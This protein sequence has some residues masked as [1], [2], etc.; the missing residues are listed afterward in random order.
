MCGLGCGAALLIHNMCCCHRMVQGRVEGCSSA[1]NQRQG[2]G[3]AQTHRHGYFSV[4]GLDP[5]ELHQS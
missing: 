4:L 2:D 1:E 3:Q 5:D